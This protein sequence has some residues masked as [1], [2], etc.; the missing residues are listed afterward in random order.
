M[1]GVSN[2]FDPELW[3]RVG[4]SPVE[5]LRDISQ[6]KLSAASQNPAY[7]ALYDEVIGDFD[8]YLKRQKSWFTELSSGKQDDVYAYFCM[9]YGWHEAVA[10]YSGGLGVL[11]DATKAYQ[12]VALK[13]GKVSATVGTLGR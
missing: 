3:E 6:E 7:L 5:M 9:E 10:L 12:L 2:P 4:H 11:A 13:P 8:G 1:G